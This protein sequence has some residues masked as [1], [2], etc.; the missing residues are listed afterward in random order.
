MTVFLALLSAFLLAACVVLGLRLLKERARRK[1][2]GLFG[3]YPIKT[4]ALSTFD[5]VFAADEFGPGLETEVR[6]ISQGDVGAVGGTTDLESWILCVLSKRCRT[7][8]EFGTCSGKTTYH[9]ARNSPADC[10]VA[11]LTLNP[12]TVDQYRGDDAGDESAAARNALLESR[13]EQFL[14]TGTDVEE[15]VRQHFGDSKAFDDAPYAGRCDLIFVDGSHARSYVE[16]DTEKALAMVR[17]EGGII[18]WHDYSPKV[19]G[20]Y[21]TLNAYAKKLPLAHLAGTNMVAYKA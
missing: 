6:F 1:R 18:I 4:V 19:K 7:I 17:R 20:V 12:D 2:T 9:M 5:P 21:D 14:Y 3:R 8:F 10:E 13:F 11:T 16:S 15:K